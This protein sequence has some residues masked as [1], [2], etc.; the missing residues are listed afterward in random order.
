LTLLACLPKTKTT[1][2]T[3]KGNIIAEELDDI[4]QIRDSESVTLDVITVPTKRNGQSSMTSLK[5]TEN[6]NKQ[7]G[8]N[9]MLIT[10]TLNG[11]KTAFL[12]DINEQAHKDGSK[13]TINIQDMTLEKQSQRYKLKNK[14]GC[15]SSNKSISDTVI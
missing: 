6:N 2:E 3:Y 7:K 14:K 1:Y 4:I 5:S 12:I 15:H 8:V 13:L 9:Y 10:Y 11:S